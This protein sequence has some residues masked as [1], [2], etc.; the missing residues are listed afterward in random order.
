MY[1]IAHYRTTDSRWPREGAEMT[2]EDGR[3]MVRFNISSATSGYRVDV[4][5]YFVYE[6]QTYHTMTAFTPL[7]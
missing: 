1:C 3:G 2:D 7:F 5:V 6:G 4:D